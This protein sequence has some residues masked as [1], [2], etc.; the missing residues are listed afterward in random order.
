[1]ASVVRV[2]KVFA[3]AIAEANGLRWTHQRVQ[4]FGGK[5]DRRK[6]INALFGSGRI[7]GTGRMMLLDLYVDEA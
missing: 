6:F 3:N 7:N 4:S 2:E 5:A 1:M